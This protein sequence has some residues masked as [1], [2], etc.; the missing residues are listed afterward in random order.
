MHCKVM[1][2]LSMVRFI[3]WFTSL[4]HSLLQ[5]SCWMHQGHS[6]PSPLPDSPWKGEMAEAGWTLC[7]PRLVILYLSCQVSAGATWKFPDEW[8]LTGKYLLDQMSMFVECVCFPWV[9]LLLERGKSQTQKKKKNSIWKCSS[10]KAV[11]PK[12]ALSCVF[13]IRPPLEPQM[14]KK[15]TVS[16][17]LL[18]TAATFPSYNPSLA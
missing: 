9:S 17:E 16:P 7:F 3:I 13:P 14:G 8:F 11:W 18:P 2:E 1:F 5:P 4:Q 15:S 12:F 10:C 6:L